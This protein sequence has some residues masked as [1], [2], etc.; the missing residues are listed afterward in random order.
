MAHSR[1][2]SG[3]SCVL[4]LLA[5]AA[6]VAAAWSADPATNTLVSGDEGGCVISHAATGA[7]GSSWIAW[8]DSESGYDIRLQ[9]LDAAGDPV[10]TAPVLIEDQSLSWV[11]DYDLAVDT[12][13]RAAI[14]WVGASSVGAAL[15]DHDGSILWAHDFASGSGA[16]LGQAQI[17]GTTDG[18]VVVGWLQDTESHFQRVDESGSLVWLTETVI[19]V[20]GT[21]IV[22]D[23]TPSTDGGVVASFVHYTS[24]QG[25]KTLKAQRISAGGSAT[26]GLAPRDVFTS[27]SLQFG[28]FPE[29]IPDDTGGGVFSWYGVSPLMARLQRID[30]GG[31][32]LWGSNGVAVTNE[33]SMVH[34]SPSA[35]FDPE[36][37]ETTVYWVRQ[38]SLQSSAGVQMNRFDGDG[39]SLWGGMGIQVVAPSSQFSILDL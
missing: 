16:Y 27:G 8:F 28:A 3:S 32:V 35:S 25:A 14:A 29:F 19:S 9:R 20:S 11:Q 15:V 26:W 31:A 4:T 30:G 37:G 1:C 5:A 2:I 23:I 21:L 18:D 17:S 22:S 36:S 34:V 39:Q 24:F 38:D 10:W 13:G 7:D 12:S 6:P 33:S